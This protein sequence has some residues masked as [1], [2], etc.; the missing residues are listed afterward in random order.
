MMYIGSNREWL[1]RQNLYD[2]LCEMNDELETNGGGCIMLAFIEIE[3]SMKDCKK[4]KG[5]CA[6]HISAWLAEKHE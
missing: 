2:L 4:Y 6:E 3:T 5:Q 1:A